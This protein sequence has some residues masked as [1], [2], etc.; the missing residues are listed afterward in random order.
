[1]TSIQSLVQ[2]AYF[3]R[4]IA[5]GCKDNKVGF[6]YFVT[7]R[8]E[9]SKN[10]VLTE[11][12]TGV[13]TEPFD[14]KLCSDPSLIIYRAVAY[15]SDRVIV[16]NGD[17]TDT[18]VQAGKG[19]FFDALKTRLY[20]PDGPIFTPRIA[21]EIDKKTGEYSLAILKRG[22][23]GECLRELFLYEPTDG[24]GRL[25]TTYDGTTEVKAFLGEPKVFSMPESA[26]GLAMEIWRGLEP[27]FR[28]GVYCCYLDLISGKIEKIIVNEKGKK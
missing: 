12:A 23:E 24:V 21:A 1:M 17:H 3:G 10:R 19:R 9:N 22:D 15:L 2:G 8:S 4:G 11:R 18:V 26:E 7:G 6:A 14:P 28:V 5:V 27:A 16:T 25:V 13:Y 20:E